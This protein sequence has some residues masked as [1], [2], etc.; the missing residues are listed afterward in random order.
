MSSW[1][2]TTATKPNQSSR[3]G[4]TLG[5]RLQPAQPDG[6]RATRLY[7]QKVAPEGI[8]ADSVLQEGFDI[9]SIND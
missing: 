9:L 2:T 4:V 8:F 3:V 1:I 6:T 5:E 7:V